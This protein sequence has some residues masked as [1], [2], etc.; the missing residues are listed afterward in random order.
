MHKQ[1]KIEIM[2]NNMT[3]ANKKL[4]EFYFIQRWNLSWLTNAPPNLLSNCNELANFLATL[5]FPYMHGRSN[6]FFE[7]TYIC[8]IKQWQHILFSFIFNNHVMQYCTTNH[9]FIN[10]IH[11]PQLA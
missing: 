10:C 2:Q 6:N 5:C 1:Y 8:S 4:Q 3:M 7:V 9:E 11:L